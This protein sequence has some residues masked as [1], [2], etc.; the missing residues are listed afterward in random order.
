MGA[1]GSAADTVALLDLVDLDTPDSAYRSRADQA[2]VAELSE[3]GFVKEV[4][5]QMTVTEGIAIPGASLSVAD[6]AT[7]SEPGRQVVIGRTS[8]DSF[9]VAEVAESA[10]V[11]ITEKSATDDLTVADAAS[12]GAAPTRTD[13]F[14]F[15]EPIRTLAVAHSRIDILTQNEIALLAITGVLPTS[16]NRTDQFLFSEAGQLFIVTP[17]PPPPQPGPGGSVAEMPRTLIDSSYV[18]PSRVVHVGA[19]ADL[20]VAINAAQRG[21]E[22]VLEAGATFTGAYFFPP[23]PGTGVITITSGTTL[24]PEGTRMRPSLATNLAKLR[25]SGADLVIYAPSLSSGWRFMGLDIGFTPET[26]FAYDMIRI[27]YGLE[28][29]AANVAKDFIF[30]RCYIHGYSGVSF[31]RAISLNGGATAVVDCWFGECHGAGFDSQCIGGWQGTGPWKVVNNYLEGAG[32]NFLTGGSDTQIFNNV[33]SDIEFRRN[34]CFKPLSWLGVWTVKNL[35]ELKSARRV[36]MEGNVFENNWTDGQ[37]GRAILFTV[38]NQDGSNPWAT[39]EDVTYKYNLLKGSEHGIHFL[40]TDYLY[41]SQTIARFLFEH[42]LIQ[43]AYTNITWGGGDDIQFYHNIFTGAGHI[44][45]F[46]GLQALRMIYR[47]NVSN[48]GEY[49]VF[50]TGG[51]GQPALDAEAPDADFNYNLLYDGE[52]HSPAIYPPSNM[53]SAG[54]PF[55]GDFKLLSGSPFA[56]Q[57]SDGTNPGA[58]MDAI[59]AATAGV[60]MA[61]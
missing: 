50:G 9:S 21:D 24:P 46:A 25:Q 58:D 15:T 1:E 18:A 40:G 19:G 7:L 44:I 4:D 11:V 6:Q 53:Y 42:N 34:H 55:G 37:A 59:L 38:R 61:P 33:P 36:W 45:Q 8:T 49:G 5:D 41:P 56:G 22:L 3:L 54:V 16:H 23:K 27:G 12:L 2:V 39:I 60:V 43:V 30:D 10:V 51:I 47:D 31:Q 35:F 26:T 29:N 57:A 17:P 52:R 20:Q 32:E 48:H 28:T 13:S 14:L